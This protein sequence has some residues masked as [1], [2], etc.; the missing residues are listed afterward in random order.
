MIIAIIIISFFLEGI[1]TNLISIHSLLIPLFTVTS[2][3]ILYPYFNSNNLK[4][5]SISAIVGFF[6]DIIYTDSLFVN[7]LSFAIISIAIIIIYNYI[8]M[9]WININILNIVVVI[10]YKIVSYFILSLV[11][12][13]KFS[14]AV[15]IR[16]IYQSIIVNVL[17]GLI[18][19]FVT[20]KVGKQLNLKKME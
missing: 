19:Y 8:N 5:V 6:Y 3:T 18:I 13:L 9:N 20:Y 16:G 15:M 7:T 11:G 17:Y 12:Y 10:L 14:S 2:L 4:F 1:F